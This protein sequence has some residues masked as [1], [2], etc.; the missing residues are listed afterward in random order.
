MLITPNYQA[1]RGAVEKLCLGGSML[2][3]VFTSL[4]IGLSQGQDCLLSRV[5]WE[6]GR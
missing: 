6:K 3:Q 4:G 2:K 5:Q 1:P